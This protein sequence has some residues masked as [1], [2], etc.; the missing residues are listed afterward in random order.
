MDL[1]DPRSEAHIGPCTDRYGPIYPG[2]EAAF[3]DLQQPAHHPY[4]IGGLIRLHEPEDFFDVV[5]VSLANQAAAF[6]RI[7]RS[8]RSCLFSRRSRVSSSRSGVLSPSLRFPASRWACATQFEIDCAAQPNSWASSPGDRP[9]FTRSTI[10]WRNSGG[11]GGLVRGIVDSCAKNQVST[12]AGQL[13]FKFTWGLPLGSQL[14]AYFSAVEV[15]RLAQLGALSD[16]E[17]QHVEELRRKQGRGPPRAATTLTPE[18]NSEV[19][20]AELSAY[21]TRD[22]RTERHWAARVNERISTLEAVM[23]V[24]G[25][26]GQDSPGLA[27]FVT[28]ARRICAATHVPL[29]IRGSPPLIYPL[30]EPLLQREVIE[31]LL[32]R[33]AARWPERA[34][35]LVTAYHDVLAGVPLDEVF[36]SA[37]KSVEQIAR[38]LTGDPKFDF[39][40]ADLNRHFPF[41][42]PTIKAGITR[43]RAHRGDSAAHGRK[44]PLPSEIRFLLF[45]ICNLALLLLDTQSG[46]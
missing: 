41:L 44:A 13:H 5:P 25:Q 24:A 18:E 22:A 39:S 43:L 7:S 45:Q 19:L 26:Y 15:R 11:Y 17:E 21:S 38:S 40:D 23:R 12:K 31:P 27:A 32:G 4:R 6:E 1:V 8:I 46:D 16:P 42:H 3:G 34:K 20:R 35:E 36:S 30:E 37:F 2:I 9:A 29:D 10:C 14:K 28:D 33:L